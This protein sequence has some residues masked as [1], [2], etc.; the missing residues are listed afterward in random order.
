MLGHADLSTTQ[1]YT[2]VSIR[3]LK[4]IHSATHPAKLHREGESKANDEDQTQS[5]IDE[6]FSS[7][8]AEE[9]EEAEDKE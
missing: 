2:Q 9:S 6:L 3:Q 1:I 7:L 4:E 8:A 5:D